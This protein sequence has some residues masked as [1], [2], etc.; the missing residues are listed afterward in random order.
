MD[1]LVRRFGA[2]P[3][4]L[5]DLLILVPANK[6]DERRAEYPGI[7]IQPLK[8]AASELQASHWRF[9]MGAVGNQA[10]Y[11]RQLDEIMRNLRN[12][13]TLAR[14]R[15]EIETSSLPD[16]LKELARV[17]LGLASEYIGDR[18]DPLAV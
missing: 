10:T 2:N 3:Q 4:G 8:F 16:H 15:Q 11:I 1:Q 18:K 9:L 6:L 12:D 13:L 5:N 17:R 14:F 7:Q